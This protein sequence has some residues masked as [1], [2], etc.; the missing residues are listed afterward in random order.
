MHSSTYIAIPASVLSMATALARQCS[1]TT[2]RER[3]LISQAVAL[4]VSEHLQRT[5][6]LHTDAGRSASLRYAELLDICDYQANGWRVEMRSVTHVERQ[7][8]YVPTMPLMVGVLADFYVGVQVDK[9]LIGAEML[10]WARGADLAGAELSP[11]G[12]F[13]SLPLE[14]LQPFAVLPEQLR[15]ARPLD[16]RQEHAFEAWQARAERIMRGVREVL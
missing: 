11:N 4:A 12:L 8:L 5:A 1:A 10:G 13:A 14:E 3:V 2:V 16:A 6:G 7:A 9:D 15:Q